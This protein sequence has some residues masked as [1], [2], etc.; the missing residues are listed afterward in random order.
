MRVVVVGGGAVGAS[1]AF[2]LATCPGFAG[3]I[4]VLERD[5]SYARASTTLS[6][7]SI[8]TQFSTPE[9]IRLSRYGWSL[10]AEA[11]RRLGVDC[12]LRDRG[13]LILASAAGA[14]T[15]RANHAVQRAEGADVAL[16]GPA[17]IATRF[18]W[19]SVA[20][21]ALGALGLSGEGWFDAAS[22]LQGLKRAAISAG[23]RFETADA[24]GFDRDGAR[25][26]AVVAADGRRFPADV[27][28]NAAGAWGGETAARAGLRLPV[29]GAKRTV[30]RLLC[31]EGGRIAVESPLIVDPSGVWMRPEGQGFIAGVS[32][33][34]DR[35]P[36]AI[37]FE[38]VWDDYEATVWPALAARI[39]AFEALRAERAWAGWYEMS[40]WDANGFVG[41]LPEAPNLIH[42]CGFSG[43]GVQHAAGVGRAVA[44]LVATGGF[45]TLDLAALS[46]ERVARGE[47]VIERAVI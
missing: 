19:L 4:V 7:A 11:P 37:D 43:H 32:P 46:P 33:P 23:A 34:P 8:R 5:P 25:V 47:R 35:D 18:P 29:R 26:V 42:A 16:L 10:L 27:A 3:E 30:F 24:A 1:V 40:D 28:V 39:P 31:R 6:A 41:A 21:V 20:G 44:E 45:R 2:H 12:A 38:P 14:P 36:P 15:L 22:L 17:E 9:N 13:Y